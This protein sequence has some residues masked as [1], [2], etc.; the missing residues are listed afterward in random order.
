MKLLLTTISLCL[1]ST[2]AI[3]APQ[4]EKNYNS[5]AAEAKKTNT[6][7]AVLV[8]GSSWHPASKKFINQLWTA[9]AL[10]DN[11]TQPLILTDVEIHQSL[12]KEEAKTDAESRKGWNKKS[13]YSYPALQIYSASGELLQ[14]YQGRQLRGCSTQRALTSHLNNLAEAATER[15]RLMAE[16]KS[17]DI[18]DDKK[19][20]LELL[21]KLLKLPLIHGKPVVELLKAADAEDKTGWQARL[22]FNES[23][24][25]RHMTRLIN[26][27]KTKQALAEVTELL[28]K[29]IYTPAQTAALHG[30]KGKVLVAQKDFVG[31]WA[32]FKK[33][34]EID[35]YGSTGNT[36]RNYGE[37]RAMQQ[38]RSGFSKTSALYGKKIGE[39]ISRDFATFKAS[40]IEYD[41][42][43]HHGSLVKGDHSP[44]GFAFHTA[45]EKGAHIIMDLGAECEVNALQ[46]LNRSE[47]KLYGRAATLRLSV[48]NDQL[49]W[50]TVWSAE[51]AE[52]Q[53]DIM[54]EKSINSRYLKLS[55]HS[56]K[57]EPL[58]LK[59]VNVFGKR[60]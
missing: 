32:S 47:P 4:F 42:G 59:A 2:V 3:A 41:D 30:A 15:A 37:L 51:K 20:Q 9:S 48:S 6:P 35:P 23:S 7:F 45:V 34:Y 21:V 17:P 49:T 24:Y 1:L 50:T 57:P 13:V 55:L 8:H 58:H 19:G 11:V 29:S 14:N 52:K 40:S 60:R 22:K 44:T 28:E 56:P 33:A 31:A 36:M 18:A 43:K 38:S 53:W 39:N 25:L 16:L 54:L 26:E 5:A 46:I 12:T 27:K 10:G